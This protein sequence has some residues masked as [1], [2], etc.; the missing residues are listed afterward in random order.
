[1]G[2]EEKVSYKNISLE[3]GFMQS[4]EEGGKKKESKEHLKPNYSFSL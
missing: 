1:M 3:M 2:A 4:V